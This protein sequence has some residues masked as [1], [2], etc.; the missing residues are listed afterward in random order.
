MSK[1]INGPRNLA[2]L[3]L[4]LAMGASL[5]TI[6]AAGGAAAQDDQVD[7][8]PT[9]ATEDGS[10]EPTDTIVVTGSRIAKKEFTSAAPVQVVQGDIAR[11]SGLLDIDEILQTSPQ[12]T[13]F[14]ID[15]SFIPFVLDNGP[16]ATQVSFRGLDPERTLVLINGRRMAPAGVGGAPT[17]PDISLI[18]TILIDRIESLFDGASS[19]YGS[20]AIAGVANVILRRDFDGFQIDADAALPLQGGGEQYTVAASWG[21][22]GDNGFVGFGA[23]YQTNNR[24]ARSQRDFLGRCEQ[25][26]YYTPDGRI[27]NQDINYNPGVTINEC[28][29]FPLTNRIFI[30]IGFGSVYYTPGTSNIFIPNFSETQLGSTFDFDGDGLQDVDFKDPF[31]AYDASETAQNGDFL[32]DNQTFSIY[33]YG[34]YDTGK[35]GNITPFFEAMYSNRQTHQY[36]PGAQFFNNVPATNPFNPCNIDLADNGTPGDASDDYPI[37]PN[38]VNCLA[39]FGVNFGSIGDIQPILN[40]NGDRDSRETE[41]SQFRFVGGLKGELPWLD[42]VLGFGG[43]TWEASGSYSRST[44]TDSFQGIDQDRLEL[45]LNTS[46]RNPDGTVT[47]GGTVPQVTPCVPVN[48]FAPN[49]YVEGGG[50]FTPEEAAYLFV[51]ADFRTTVEQTLA[52]V[53]VTGQVATL[54]WNDNPLSIVVG[55]EWREDAIDSDPSAFVR[56]GR[57]HNRASDRGATGKRDLYE[58]FTEL[59]TDLLSDQPGV[60]LLNINAAARWTEESNYGSAWTY[61]VKGIYKPVNWMTFRG[62]YGTS[63][64]APN[65]REQFLLGGT[66]FNNVTDPCIVPLAARIPS[67]NPSLPPTYDPT[68]DNRSPF[69]ISQCQA[70]GVNPLTLGIT[71]APE[72]NPIQSVEILTGGSDQLEDEESRAYTA[73]VVLEQPWTNAFGLTVSATY[74]NVVV[75]DSV[76]EPG[77]ADVLR[78]CYT[79]DSGASSAFCTRV[80][81]DA[82]GFISLLDTSFINIGSLTSKGVDYNILLTK[83]FEAF[84]RPFD[85]SLDVRLSQ[86]LE[87]EVEVLGSVDDNKGETESPTWRGNANLLVSTG[88]YRFNWFTRWIGKGQEDIDLSDPVNNPPFVFDLACPDP[89]VRPAGTGDVCRPV[90]FTG[91]YFVHN[92]SFTWA[93]GD[94]VITAGLRNVFDRGPELVDADGVFSVFN[95]PIGVGYDLQG[96]TAFASIRKSF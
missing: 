46:V 6:A 25:E 21:M 96:R 26:L 63:Y 60:E 65:S 67:G 1:K 91:N 78:E 14:Q 27:L 29:Q 15:Q 19:V 16:G 57:I 94:W 11:E 61:S 28:V 84:D 47:C 53:F 79:I 59:D 5:A 76:E 85:A 10:T 66:G 48:L 86:L 71:T 80:T 81:R 90:D 58:F 88:D 4:A 3:R 38:G 77:I 83:E 70:Q 23:E 12:S 30:P 50:F 55:G 82:D 56:D 69:T 51:P 33:A 74:Y 32:P 13:G 49:L 9:A 36:S 95:V 72:V 43:F 37:N 75:R 34:E 54:P 45:S 62:T 44:G 20:D 42:G 87:Q 89:T 68:Q 92:M 52:Q 31:Y 2:V 7:Q 40:I 39:I 8:V 93:P 18:P 73:G 17:T 22:S 41:V 35:G 24:V 64:R